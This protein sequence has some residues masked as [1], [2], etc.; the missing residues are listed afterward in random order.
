[1]SRTP[2]SEFVDLVTEIR[3]V[4]LHG[5][6]AAGQRRGYCGYGQRVALAE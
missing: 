5:C 1:M 6:A 4:A 2:M 3:S